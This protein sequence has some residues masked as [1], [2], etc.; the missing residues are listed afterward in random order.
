[1]VDHYYK[2]TDRGVVALVTG[3]YLQR[4]AFDAQLKKL[5]EVFGG[6]AS[7]MRSGDS[8]YVGGMKP[9]A[10]DDL[11]IHWC[12]PDGYG[13][14]SLR[15]NPTLPTGASKVQRQAIRNEHARLVAQWQEH[16]PQ[17]ISSHATWQQLGV[18][19]GNLMLSGGIMFELDGAA[20][21][22]LG[23]QINK[24]EH[25]ECVA[26]RKPTSGWIEGAVEILPSEYEAARRAR[27][28]QAKEASPA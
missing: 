3:W 15:R 26:A 20:Y 17:R 19:T 8:V 13:Y 21:F 27:N 9:P 25:Q 6:E 12:Q 1:M 5:G 4:D 16:C 14:R 23:F 10:S 22:L 18:N 24:V 28:A 2:S 11:A 7:S